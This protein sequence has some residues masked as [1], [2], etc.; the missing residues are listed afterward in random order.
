MSNKITIKG[1]P[2]AWNDSEYLRRLDM[3]L[4][5]YHHTAAS[6][7]LVNAPLEHD[8][9]NLVIEKSK[10]GYSISTRFPIRHEQ[11]S[12]TVYMTK[13]AEIQAT[14]IEQLKQK[15]K[16]EYVQHLESE[17]VRYQDLLRE[18]L[19]QAQAE[20]ERVQREREEA[21]KIE[22]INKQVQAC[23]TP[24]DIPDDIP[25]RSAA[26]FCTDMQ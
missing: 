8:F 15:T 7:E 11:L 2:P 9:L 19:V 16:V 18:Q 26:V 25:E 17:H 4:H 13:P 3:E 12:H 14:D 1:T 23:Y 20:K 21:K 22:A 24:L 6:L 5:A 10:Q